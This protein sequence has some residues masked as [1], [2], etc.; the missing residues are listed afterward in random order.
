MEV[1][2]VMRDYIKEM[3]KHRQ[4]A[5]GDMQKVEEKLKKPYRAQKSKK[6]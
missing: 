5:A 3:T 2:Y 4:V 1:G 6:D